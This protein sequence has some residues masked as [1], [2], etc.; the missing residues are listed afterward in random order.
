MGFRSFRV[1]VTFGLIAC[2]AASLSACDSD[3]EEPKGTAG[4][5]AG[6]TGGAG[7]SAG[8]GGIGGTG[9][10]SGTGAGATGGAAGTGG[11]GTITCG[12]RTCEPGGFG[13]VP[14]CCID[15]QRCGIDPPA[16]NGA[17]IPCTE[18]DQPGTPDSTCFADRG[19][20]DASIDGGL[21]IPGCCRPNGLCGIMLNL[22]GLNFGCMDPSQYSAIYDAGPP[23]RCGDAGGGNDASI[24]SS[25]GDSSA[26]DS[27]AGDSSADDS[28]ADDSSTGDSNTGG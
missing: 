28:S 14:A 18:L 25:A 1:A 10:A 2:S 19:M 16:F 24:D 9:G 17:D 21:N 26:G 8:R 7:G 6:A 15:N 23:Q 11:M 4:T 13:F 12:T 3:D 22:P 20:A 5:G 27:S